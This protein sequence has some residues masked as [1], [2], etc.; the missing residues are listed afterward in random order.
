M[1]LVPSME[2]VSREKR[3]LL[4]RLPIATLLDH[5]EVFESRVLLKYAVGMGLVMFSGSARRI[6]YPN[7][8][9]QSVINAI[10]GFTYFDNILTFLRSCSS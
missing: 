10:N 1:N 9:Q 7:T 3:T 8:N 2:Q 6:I 5:M 4:S